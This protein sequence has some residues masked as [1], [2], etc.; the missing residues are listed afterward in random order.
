MYLR[1]PSVRPIV[2][3]N[4]LIIVV[5]IALSNNRLYGHEIKIL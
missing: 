2:R 3:A 1:I 4:S 5:L